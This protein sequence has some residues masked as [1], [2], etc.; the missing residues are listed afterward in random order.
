MKLFSVVGITSIGEIEERFIETDS[1]DSAVYQ[2][3]CNIKLNFERIL[4]KRVHESNLKKDKE[5]YFN[6]E[7]QRFVFDNKVYFKLRYRKSKSKYKNFY[8]KA[9]SYDKAVIAFISSKMKNPKNN[10]ISAF[11]IDL[12]QLQ[13]KPK[14][15]KI[16]KGQ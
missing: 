6:D 12:F 10:L 8:I 2:Y 5:I 4:V 9:T 1:Y 7:V 3:G 15:K 11:D 14:N 13:K 16:I